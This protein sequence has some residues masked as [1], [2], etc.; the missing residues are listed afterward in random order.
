MRTMKMQVGATVESRPLTEEPIPP[1]KVQVTTGLDSSGNM[2]P[3]E[4]PFDD[5]DAMQ[6]CNLRFCVHPRDINDVWMPYVVLKKINLKNWIPNW[7]AKVA[8]VR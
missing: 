4:W 2:L 3:A 6:Q 1:T 5:N 7:L 8:F